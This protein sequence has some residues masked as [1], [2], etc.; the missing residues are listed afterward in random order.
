MAARKGNPPSGKRRVRDE[1]LAKS[2]ER[3]VAANDEIDDE[4]DA[5]L[6]QAARRVA[7][8]LDE[9]QEMY[10]C[11]DIDYA[12]LTKALY[13]MPHFVGHLKEMLATPAIRASR[14]ITKEESIG[15]SKLASLRAAS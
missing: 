7:V 13:L 1:S 15:G 5:G 8:Q 11:G 9:A 4:L 10:D 14:G 2:L 3:S 12:Q 6:I